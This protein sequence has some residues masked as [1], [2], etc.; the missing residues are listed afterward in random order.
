MSTLYRHWNWKTSAMFGVGVGGRDDDAG[1]DMMMLEDGSDEEE[2]RGNR[3]D[4]SGQSRLVMNGA[5]RG[6]WLGTIMG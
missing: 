3:I 4:L 1:P 5:P 2:E 6:T